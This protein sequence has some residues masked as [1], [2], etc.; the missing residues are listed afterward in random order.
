MPMELQIIRASEFIRA[1]AHGH[2]DLDTS[3]AFLVELASACRRRGISRALLDMRALQ[4]GPTPVFSPSDLAS[5]VSAF[6]EIGFSRSDR[7]AVLYASDPHHRAR[8]FAFISKLRG[9]KVQAFGD[10][11]A[12]VTWLSETEDPEPQH[13][14]WKTPVPITFSEQSPPKVEGSLTVCRPSTSRR[15]SFRK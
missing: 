3:R 14:N 10:F 9:W 5:L 15:R 12:A 2:F 4:P 11:E 1:G 6:R 8:M 7:L 13:S